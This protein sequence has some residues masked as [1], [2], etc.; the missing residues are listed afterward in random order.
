M[1]IPNAVDLSSI[2][3]RIVAAL[4]REQGASQ[5]TLAGRMGWDRSLLSR[6]EA[7]RNTANIDNI[8]EL[9]EVFLV[10]GLIEGHGALVAL[11]SKVAHESKRRGLR[12]VV[13]RTSKPEGQQSVEVATLDRIVARIVDD[14]LVAL[15]VESDS[16]TPASPD[17]ESGARDA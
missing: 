13:G 10:D 5:A 7:G 8:F 14:F 4:R 1:T 12:P 17:A 2:I 3:G 16:N 11:T 15:R 9:E 6:I